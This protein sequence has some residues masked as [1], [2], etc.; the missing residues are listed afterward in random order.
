MVLW[1]DCEKSLGKTGMHTEE[2]IT[3]KTA[4]LET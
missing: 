2:D 1:A 4:I 3:C